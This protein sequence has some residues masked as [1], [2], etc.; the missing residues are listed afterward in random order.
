[1]QSKIL[2]TGAN[3]FIGRALCLKLLESGED[4]TG[5]VRSCLNITDSIKV[6]RVSGI[7]EK[8][9]WRNVLGGG[10]DVVVHLAARAHVLKDRAEG[11]ALEYWRVNMHGTKNIAEQAAAAGVRRFVFLSTVK[12][13]GEESPRGRSFTED[14]VPYPED[15]YARS[16]WKAEQALLELG[17]RTGMEI[18]IVRPPLVYGE[19]VKA[20]FLSMMKW[21]HC[22]YPLPFGALDNKRSLVALDNLV[23]FI[24]LCIRH[25]AAAG[26][27]FFVSDGE[28]IAVRDLLASLSRA[29]GVKMRLLPV[30]VFLLRAG[31]FCLGKSDVARRLCGSLRV[32]IGKAVRLLDWAP[33]V[34][35]EIA[36]GKVADHFLRKDLND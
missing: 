4:V 26:E 5:V 18:V 14:V 6:V 19:G 24:M 33:P 23:D 36:F 3:G 27:T 17:G 21:L 20:N 22:G 12:V 30:P 13:S 9:N 10:V 15:D 34:S 28:D 8:T 25:P 2:V 31:A 29:L 35:Q 16:K 7:D 11:S 1:M 32:D